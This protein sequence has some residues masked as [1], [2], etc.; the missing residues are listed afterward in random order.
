MSLVDWLGER[1]MVPVVPVAAAAV[2]AG[3]DMATGLLANTA[4]EV[5]HGESLG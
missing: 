3:D 2:V 5:P 1:K 4:C